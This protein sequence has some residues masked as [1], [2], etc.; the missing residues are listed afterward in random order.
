M[1]SHGDEE[2]GGGDSVNQITIIQVLKVTAWDQKRRGT[3]SMMTGK[4]S[5]VGVQIL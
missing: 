2:W 3:W 4:M 5:G 1:D